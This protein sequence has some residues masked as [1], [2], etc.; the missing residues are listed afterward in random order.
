MI[1]MVIGNWKMHKSI[2]ESADFV[3]AV[4][5][6]IPSSAE[7]ITGITGQDICLPAMLEAAK[8]SDLKIGAE[9]CYYED[10]GPY[11]GETSPLTLAEA[12]V[13]LV[14]IGHSIRRSN[15][16]DT[17]ELINKKIKGA[18][19]N[20]LTPI[21]CCDE[22]MTQSM[23]GG[24]L[25]WVVKPILTD[26]DGLTKEEVK[27]INLAYEPS[28]AIGTG[29]SASPDEA[30]EG[31]FMLRKTVADMFDNETADS[32][33]VLYGGSITPANYPQLI[34]QRDINGALIGGSSLDVD[35]FIQL[36]N[37]NA[38]FHLFLAGWQ[39]KITFR[40]SVPNSDRGE[41]KAYVFNY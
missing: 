10:S 40:I 7:Q 37:A 30:E 36:A 20:G 11:T 5:D 29:H 2:K 35:T 25:H 19:R 28:W 8:G 32:V 6:K 12:G 24:K 22:T 38:Q 34:S 9:N 23:A 16:N 33:R 1:P 18:L 21:V 17:D 31:C 13:D 15:F 39:G 14:I 3:K 26:L 4:R 27:K 41:K